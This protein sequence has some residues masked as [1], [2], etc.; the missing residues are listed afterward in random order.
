MNYIYKIHVKLV[1]NL[2]YYII[3]SKKKKK[4]FWNKNSI[5]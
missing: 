2:Y 5:N 4:S 1:E 3:K